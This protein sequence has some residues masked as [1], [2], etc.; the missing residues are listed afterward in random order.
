ML[1]VLTLAISVN[2][3]NRSTS[4]ISTLISVSEHYNAL[5]SSTS[6]SRPKT[7][8]PA[9]VS[10]VIKQGYDTLS[11]T[12]QEGL[13]SWEKYREADERVALK[14]MARLT[15]GDV[16]VLLGVVV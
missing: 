16:K 5:L 2:L 11:I 7:L 10:N 15:V 4:S 3:G 9:Q 12:A 13:D 1:P 14:K 8:S 6:T